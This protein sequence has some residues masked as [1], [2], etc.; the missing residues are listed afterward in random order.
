MLHFWY[1]QNEKKKGEK[2]THKW[3]KY[4]Q[5][6]ERDKN[7]ENLFRVRLSRG[8]RPDGTQRTVTKVFDDIADARVWRDVTK[9]QMGRNPAIGLRMTLDDYFRHYYIAS[10]AAKAN[11]KASQVDWVK[12]RYE[13]QISPAKPKP[14]STP[15]GKRLIEDPPS[16]D[17]VQRAICDNPA[18]SPRT[19]R[20]AIGIYRSIYDYLYDEHVVDRKPWGDHRFSYRAADRAPEGADRR[21]AYTPAEAVAVCRAL[22]AG[23]S[24]L[25]ALAAA[26]FGA[27]LRLSEGVALDTG[28]LQFADLH[29]VGRIARLHIHKSASQ[30]TEGDLIAEHAKQM[31]GIKA[32][33]DAAEVRRKVRAWAASNGI[34]LSVRHETKTSTS[35]RWV[36]IC[37]PFAGIL[38]HAVDGLDDGPICR[39]ASGAR[40]KPHS[41]PTAW[42][43]Q[44]GKGN[45]LG[46]TRFVQLKFARHTGDTMLRKSRVAFSDLQMYR[47][48]VASLG[49]DAQ[50]YFD[51]TDPEMFD[52][53]AEKVF[54][55][56][57]KQGLVDDDD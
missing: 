35:E 57:Q 54:A 48:H 40:M 44:F 12:E 13:N 37:E 5:N 47:G 53:V 26:L 21:D 25:T 6:I 31:P 20:A 33:D 24:P 56:L 1:N 14:Y 55:Y 2:V 11:V 16:I 3:Q 36:T 32:S 51:P 49:V 34:D 18:W 28:D 42:R 38:Q 19:A 8:R 10:Y 45:P 22:E 30:R 41:I 29:G 27:G 50:N 43:R 9:A 46:N 39:G 52:Y 17:S 4:E 23:A 15:F 7:D